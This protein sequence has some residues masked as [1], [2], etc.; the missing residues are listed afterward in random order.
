MRH[1]CNRQNPKRSSENNMSVEQGYISNGIVESADVSEHLSEIKPQTPQETEEDV[2]IFPPMSGGI[3]YPYQD[4]EYEGAKGGSVSQS[5][6]YTKQLYE[7]EKN[8]YNYSEICN[9]C[10]DTVPLLYNEMSGKSEVLAIPSAE[11][12]PVSMG[13][14]LNRYKGKYICID[15]WTSDGKRIEKC[16]CLLEIGQNFLVVRRGCTGE[17]TL[18]DLNCV[19]YISIYCR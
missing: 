2:P 15:L 17:L 13:G 19:R 10:M 18:I 14:Y 5:G 3:S 1:Y 9:G 16:G 8:E 7:N 12:N 11:P 4:E 6:G